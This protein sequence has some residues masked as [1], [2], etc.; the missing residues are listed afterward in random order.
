M[1]LLQDQLEQYTKKNNKE[2]YQPYFP[3]IYDSTYGPWKPITSKLESLQKDFEYLLLTN[4]GEWPMDPFVGVGL[5]RYLFENYG[6][7]ELAK[8]Q[9]RMQIQLEKYLKNISL[10][11]VDF[12][13]TAQEQDQGS[14]RVIIKYALF[15][16]TL[17]EI[18]A[19]LNKGI[20]SITNKAI[21]TVDQANVDRL[22]SSMRKLNS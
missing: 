3:L 22:A 19:S 21:R 16:T 2:Q 6:S 4:P 18:I 12:V 13:S 9:E 10:V 7:E 1:P 17:A 11:S 5:K 20:V 14:V 15:G 8:L